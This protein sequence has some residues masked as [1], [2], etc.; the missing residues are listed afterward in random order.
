MKKRGKKLFRFESVWLK[1][2]QCEEVVLEVWEE[3]LATHSNFPLNSCLEKCRLKL[4]AWN[5]NEFEHVG[6]KINELPKHLEWLELQPASPSI[7]QDIKNTRLGLNCWH[8][9]EDKMWYQRSHINWNHAWD[10][11][12]RFFHAK[13]SALQ[14]KNHIEGLMD[15][16]GRWHEDEDKMGDLVVEYY[17]ELFSTNHPTEFTELIQAIQP[18]VTPTMNRM[19]AMEFNANEVKMAVKQMYPLKALGPDGMPPLFYQHF[20]PNIG[21]VVTKTILDFVNNGVYPPNFNETHIVLI[22][23]IKEPKG[24]MDY[25]PISLCNVVFRITSKVIANRLKKILSYIISDTQSAFVHG[26]LITDNVLVAFESMHHIHLK[27]GGKKGGN[28][29]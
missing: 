9:K 17:K 11:N 3:G 5:K 24:V 22:P 14:K 1:D 10:R 20:W 7:I 26:R 21:E 18:K 13:A 29:S 4:D 15:S 12:T 16:S 2:P 23:K 8:E 25:G 28:G 19:L 27:K 6:K